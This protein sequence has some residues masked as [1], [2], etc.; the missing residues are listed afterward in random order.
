MRE[1]DADLAIIDWL[2]DGPGAAPDRLVPHTLAYVRSHPRRSLLNWGSLMA[3]TTPR[4][5]V[6]PTLRLAFILVLVALA[7]ALL[8]VYV[9]SQQRAVIPP[10]PTPT[11]TPY[12]VLTNIPGELGLSGIAVSG[13]ELW[14][15]GLDG[16]WHYVDGAWEGP[17]NPPPLAGESLTGLAVGPDGALWVAGEKTVAVLRDGVWRAAWTAPGIGWG[18]LA[19]APDGTVW[20]G[21][22]DRTLVGLRQEGAG[23]AAQAVACPNSMSRFAVTTDGTLYAGSFFYSDGAAGLAM[24]DGTTCRLVYPLGDGQDHEVADLAA[25]PNGSLVATL[26]DEER[27]GDG[28]VSRSWLVMLRNGAWS[29][30]AG[31]TN[32]FSVGFRQAIDPGGHPWLIDSERGLMRYGG[33]AWQVVAGAPIESMEMAPDGVLWYQTDRGIERIRTDEVGD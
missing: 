32:E 30:I 15:T 7:S 2:T 8:G 3:T 24:S 27:P 31:P 19:V 23:Y 14:N 18:G 4:R 17:L 29:T 25:G 16:L 6:A 10:L 9:G 12:P 1:H 20:V 13:D 28:T 26:F 22:E 33:G 21:R 11:P 5:P